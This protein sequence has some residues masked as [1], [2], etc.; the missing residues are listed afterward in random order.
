MRRGPPTAQEQ[1]PLRTLREDFCVYFRRRSRNDRAGTMALLL[2]APVATPPFASP[3][4]WVA[5]LYLAR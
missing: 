2:R 1:S 3:G 4:P 5:A